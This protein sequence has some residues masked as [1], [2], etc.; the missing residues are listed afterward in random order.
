LKLLP[1]HI[2]LVA[3]FPVSLFLACMFVILNGFQATVPLC[4]N[5]TP[6]L[7]LPSSFSVLDLNENH[8]ERI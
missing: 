4:C 1:S 7:L 3:R 2:S 8:T 5:K 6:E